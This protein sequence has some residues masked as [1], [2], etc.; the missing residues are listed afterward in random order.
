MSA[1][2]AELMGFIQGDGSVTKYQV[3]LYFNAVEPELECHYAKRM[4]DL[5]GEL[6]PYRSQHRTW[7][8]LCYCRA[9]LAAF[10]AEAGL[11]AR[12]PDVG[13]FGLDY[14]RGLMDADSTASNGRVTIYSSEPEVVR[15]V[16]KILTGEGFDLG[17]SWTLRPPRRPEAQIRIN[18]GK[19]AAYRVLRDIG[20]NAE[21][22]RAALEAAT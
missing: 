20:Y 4:V 12:V 19:T 16:R 18:G 14:L 2:L 15:G 17:T 13:P 3:T 21:R 22:K 11:K 8:R 6:E 9:R 1:E 5:F 7:T 10:F